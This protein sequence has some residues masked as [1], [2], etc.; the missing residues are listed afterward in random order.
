MNI[1][2]HNLQHSAILAPMA[3]V[4]D[5]A[6]RLLCRQHGAAATVSE[7]ISAEGLVRASDKTR[8]MLP[9]LPAEQPYAIQLFGADADHL[10]GAAQMAAEVQPDWI[11]L[12]FGCPAKKVTKRGA[13]SAVMKDLDLMQEIVSKVVKAV[14]IPVTAKIRSGW[15]ANS[16]VATEACRIIEGEGAVAVAIH[17]RTRRQAFSG[18]A[19]WAIIKEAK[20]AVSIPVIGNGD[21]KSGG[22]AQRMI[23]ETGCD[24]V[25]VGRGCYGRPWVFNQIEALLQHG[26]A[27]PD[28]T[29][30]ERLDICLEHYQLSLKYLTEERAVNEMR[31]HI[32][33]YVK[34]LRGASQLRKIVF[35][36]S[37]A[38]KVI[39]AIVQFKEA[40]ANSE[41]EA[42]ADP[43]V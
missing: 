15:D 34:G 11:D 3:G 30:A 21:I 41:T 37:D 39:E 4:A 42:P 2:G 40:W 19:D 36:I 23:A 6:F 13:G 1:A 18:S 25:M 35:H 10:A 24:A 22:D 43:A 28:P 33:W 5:T 16:I 14:N 20:E 29:P 27:L 9:F 26:T 8:H 17:A 7:L 12:N 31:K 38:D 32:G